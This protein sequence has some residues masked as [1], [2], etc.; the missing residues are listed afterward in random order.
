M[1]RKATGSIVERVTQDGRVTRALRFSAY[2]KR[3][4][5]KLGAVTPQ[6]AAKN[7]EHV[8]ADVERGLWQPERQPVA[9]VV[10]EVP[11]FHAYS[12]QWWTLH[13]CDRLAENTQTDYRWR[14][15]CHLLPFFAEMPLDRITIDEV[16]RYKAEKLN[17]GVLD[18]SSINKTLTTLGAVLQMAVSRKLTSENPVKETNV[19][20]REK[21][22]QRTYLEYAEQIEAMVEAAG[23]LDAEAAAIEEQRRPEARRTVERRAIVSTLLYSGIRINELCSLKWNEVNLADGRLSVGSKTEAGYRSIRLRGAL[24]EE[25]AVVKARAV[26]AGLTDYVFATST[27]KAPSVDNVRNRV[28]KKTAQRARENMAA[29]GVMLFPDGITPHSLRRTFA[30]LLA[31]VGES[32]VTAMREMGHTKAEFT[33]RVYAQSMG[34]SDGEVQ[35]LKNLLDAGQLA[36]QLAHEPILA[37]SKA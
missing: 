11:T 3:R 7:L 32:P 1:A 17:D 9:E 35:K 20:L 29:E 13:G 18:E 6:E 16:D 24:R 5:V 8:L 21:T 4:F 31:A 37:A 30:S 19:K 23:Q 26:H 14:L 36:H 15:E 12:E 34:R 33:L 22:K 27:G 2:G 10:K 25:L 28:V